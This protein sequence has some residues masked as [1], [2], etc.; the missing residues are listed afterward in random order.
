M[1]TALISGINGQDGSYL[2][3]FL[4]SKGYEVIGT[5]PNANTNQEHILKIREK[6]E[7]VEANLLDQHLLEDILRNRQPDEVY[8]LAARA[9]SSELWTEPVLTGELNALSVTRLLDA[10]SKV[11]HKVRFVQ[12][13]SSEVFGNAAEV[14]QTEATPFHPR[15]P[16]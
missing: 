15:N 10:I 2:A 16:Y 9:S 13:S 14:P 5:T 3:E 11:D 7:I 8:N 1:P 12:A 6:I 4:L